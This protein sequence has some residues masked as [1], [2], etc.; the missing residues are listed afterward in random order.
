[1]GTESGHFEYRSYAEMVETMKQLNVSSGDLVDLFIAQEK[2]GLIYPPEL[3]C[4]EADGKAPCKQFVL[5]ITNE[6]TIEPTRPQVFFSGALHGNER[7]GPQATMEL[8]L[9]LTSYAKAYVANPSLDDN[10]RRTQE[11]IWR[12]VNTRDIY[13]MPM[14]NAQGYF[15]NTREEN[16][17]DPNR[18]YNYKVDG[19]C[20]EA[21]T[22][23]AVNELWRDHLFQLAM[24]FHGGMRCVTYEWG[25]PNH[26]IGTRSERSPDDKSQVLLGDAL[27][28]F[29]GPFSDGKYY[30][31]GTMNDVVYGVYG[32]MEDWAYAAS[33]ENQFAPEPIFTPCKPEQYGGYPEEKTIYNNVTHR[34]FNILVETSDSKHPAQSTLGEKSSIY[35]ADLQA[36]ASKPEG[37]VPQDMR[38]GLLLIDMV[39]PYV[40]WVSSKAE[41]SQVK[42]PKRCSAITQSNAVAD[43]FQEECVISS[44][45]SHLR[46]TWEVL[47]S[48]QVDNTH[49]ELSTDPNFAQNSTLTSIKLSGLTK[50]G[51]YIKGETPEQPQTG[52]NGPLFMDCMA[53]PANFLQSQKLYTRVAATVD[54]NWAS[55][56]ANPAPKVG[57]QSHLVNARTNDG[58][59]V[60][61]NG[62]QIQGQTTF[63]SSVKTIQF[64]V[65][66]N[67][68]EEVAQ[69]QPHNNDSSMLTVMPPMIFVVVI[70]SLVV[71][72]LGIV[73][74]KR[75]MIR[76]K[77]ANYQPTAKSEADAIEHEMES[78]DDKA[79]PDEEITSV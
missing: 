8:A 53:I 1:M 27:S 65:P 26:M 24:T 76:R 7:I 41:W 71:L 16:G 34:A 58:Y 77:K 13:L 33:W 55:D 64:A 2:Y 15:K 29:A 72:L 52:N 17:I 45:A 66:Q 31:T 50:R 23:R 75:R 56:N 10:V 46:T 48:F 12:L 63:Y 5:R 25:S 54:Q 73:L 20:M 6:S 44:S 61:H 42:A 51:Y 30:P 22:S 3:Q 67:T 40:R 78:T 47:G 19:N 38:L 28:K 70:S 79:S 14:T 11:W 69:T 9:L 35:Q 4:E 36:L 18:D 74:Y 59:F 62:Y 43:C 39:Q 49:L 60:S 37:H 57:P 68:T 21:M 32:G